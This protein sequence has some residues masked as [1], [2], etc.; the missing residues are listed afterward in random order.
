M[1]AKPS[2]AYH[3]PSLHDL[4]RMNHVTKKSGG[5]P[6]NDQHPTKK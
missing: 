3:K 2:R 5:Y 4:G 6:D 1:S